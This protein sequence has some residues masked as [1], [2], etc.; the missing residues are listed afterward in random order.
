MRVYVSGP[1]RG[2]RK[3]NFPIFDEVTAFLREQGMTVF[4]P[5]EHDRETQPGI[6]RWPGFEAGDEK[7]CPLFDYATAMQWDLARIAESEA[8]VLLPGWETSTGAKIERFVAEH[9]G[10]LIYLARKGKD[11]W[12]VYPDQVRERM[13]T[14]TF[15]EPIHQ[16]KE[17]A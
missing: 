8:I 16:P 15:I 4:S 2:H 12:Y 7:Q 1:M 9:T 17:A 13:A 6:E 10:S 11:G 14:P 3:F 5:A